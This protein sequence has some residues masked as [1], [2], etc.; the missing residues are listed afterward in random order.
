MDGAEI[1]G[2]VLN[3]SLSQPNQQGARDSSGGSH[4]K[5]VWSTD[6]WFQQQAGVET[7]ADRQEKSREQADVTQ[8]KEQVAMP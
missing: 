7:E 8:L 5:A 6:E 4:N 1:M 2:K 3:V